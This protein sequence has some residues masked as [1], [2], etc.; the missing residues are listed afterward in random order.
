MLLRWRCFDG[1]AVDGE[2]QEGGVVDG[3]RPDVVVEKKMQT[4]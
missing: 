3:R 2:G 4:S 1:G